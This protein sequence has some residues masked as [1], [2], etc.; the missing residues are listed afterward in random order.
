MSRLTP[1][2]PGKK[3]Y[4]ALSDQ[5][6]RQWNAIDPSVSQTLEYRPC[7]AALKSGLVHPCVYVVDAQ[8]YINTW[9]V[10]PEDDTGKTSI[11]VEDVSS[12][13]ESPFRLPRAFANELYR[14]GESGMGYTVFTLV[15]SD[16]SEIAVVG[17]NAIDF[18]P[19]PEGKTARDIVRVVAHKGRDRNPVSSPKYSWC[20]FGSGE[21]R[22]S[23]VSKFSGQ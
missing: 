15:F 20:L 3:I 4:P 17:G 11:R 23:G 2:L 5:L 12:L 18:V 21:G 19:L 7:S 13:S 16:H 22:T 14:A 8:A 10:W 1:Y 6:R 9:G